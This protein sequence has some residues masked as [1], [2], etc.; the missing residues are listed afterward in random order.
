[1]K[2]KTL[3]GVAVA[4][5]A[6]LAGAIG[7]AETRD[8]VHSETS[9][10]CLVHLIRASDRERPSRPS[11]VTERLKAQLSHG[12]QWQQLW[13]VNRQRVVLHPDEVT[14]LR[15]SPECEVEIEPVSANVRE[16]RIYIKG[17]L[18]SRVRQ[19]VKRHSPIINGASIDES[20]AWLVAVEDEPDAT[21]DPQLSLRRT[22]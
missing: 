11:P 4:C 22:P 7:I 2:R 17:V 21:S 16:T 20:G 9:T 15:L 5:A 13:E 12:F 18:A 10:S 3:V 14:K 1:M 8:K 19:N 6:I